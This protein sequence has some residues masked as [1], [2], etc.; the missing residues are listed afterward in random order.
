MIRGSNFIIRHIVHGDLAALMFLMND[1]EVRGEYL[2]SALQS[3]IEV[4]RK[5]Q[6]GA[7]VNDDFVRFVIVDVATDGVIGTI[8]YFKGVPYFDAREIGYTIAPQ[9]RGRGIATEAVGLLVRYLF[10]STRFNRLEI[11]MDSRNTASENVAIKCGFRKEGVACG[12]NFVRG[13]HVD[14]NVYALLRH[15][16]VRT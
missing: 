2:P 12:A 5:I 4:E 8:F 16:A 9:A 3:P 10:N 7:M 14:M 6:S 11:R 13:Q 1:P 15:E